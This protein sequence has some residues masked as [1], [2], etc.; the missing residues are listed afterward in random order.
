MRSQMFIPKK[1]KIGFQQRHDTFTKKLAY[2]IYYDERGQLRKEKSWESWRDKSIET[3]EIENVPTKGFVLNK[4]VQR[5]GY[6][7]NGRSVIRVHDPR[8]FEFEIS[9]DNLIGVLMHS[10][11]CSREIQQDCVFAWY[12]TDLVL[13]P[14]NSVEYQSSVKFTD[15]QSLKLSTKDLVPGRTYVKKKSEEQ[16]VYLGFFEVFGWEGDRA[17]LNSY[18][19][20]HR[21]KS[22]IRQ[23]SKGKKHIFVQPSKRS[24]RQDSFSTPSMSTLAECVDESIHTDYS[25][26]MDAFLSCPMGSLITGIH[27]V[28]FS[29]DA[30]VDLVMDRSFCTYINPT[31]EYIANSNLGACIDTDG[32]ITKIDASL[33]ISFNK[34]G[35]RT[36]PG[37]NYTKDYFVRSSLHTTNAQLTRTLSV[38]EPGVISESFDHVSRE[39]YT[40]GWGWRGSRYYSA[41]SCIQMNEAI[42]ELSEKYKSLPEDR[43]LTVDE[44]VECFNRHEIKI[45]CT[46][47]Q[48][49]KTSLTNFL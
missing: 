32:K 28:P 15:K 22:E 3:I 5:D 18:A 40:G 43:T 33:L 48:S 11:C 2:V 38:P 31:G 10:D 6:W 23:V 27:S 39:K 42:R 8:E 17:T 13:L 35:V 25:A 46:V 36:K 44:V 49:G 20:Q 1:L 16:L 41:Q 12:G 34:T 30:L 26:M 14:T 9:V 29:A 37:D 19:D 45:L 21:L 47:F 7:G 24:Y 4:G